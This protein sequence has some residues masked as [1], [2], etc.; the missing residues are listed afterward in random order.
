MEQILPGQLRF[1]T[2]KRQF[3]AAR[4]S[5]GHRTTTWAA[6]DDLAE[7]R[8]D[9]GLDTPPAADYAHSLVSLAS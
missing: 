8:Q 4:G 7:V 2:Q 5:Q 3:L 9:A 6:D 1:I